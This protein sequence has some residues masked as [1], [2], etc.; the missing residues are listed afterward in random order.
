M[1]I[2]YDWRGMPI[3]FTQYP[4]PENT[5]VSG[6]TLYKMAMTYDGT[7]RRI[8]KTRWVKARGDAGWQ[9]RHVTH[10]TGIGTEVRE[11]FA[12]PAKETKVV[13]NMPQGLGRYGIEKA[14]HAAESGSA[15]TFEWFLKNHLGSTMLVYGTG[16]T[17]G[18][19]KAAY[20]YRSFGEQVTLTSPST[21]KVTENFTGK[22]RDDET[23]LVYFGARYL[24]PL[25]GMWISVVPARLFASPYLYAGN[26]MNPMNVIDPD[27][28]AA[29]VYKD[30]NEVNVYI[31]VIFSGEAATPENIAYIKKEVASFFTG[32]YGKY[33]VT[34]SIF[35]LPEGANGGDPSGINKVTLWNGP[36]PKSKCQRGSCAHIGREGTA[37]IDM[38]GK[39]RRYHV[40]H[41]FAHLLGLED[42][43]DYDTK[44]P[45]PTYENNLMGK[46]GQFDLKPEQ[47]EEMWVP[48]SRKGSE[49]N[50]VYGPEK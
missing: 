43:Y 16:G 1:K 49:G 18:G 21:G 36:A 25:L 4:S 9:R 19:L 42:K 20:D 22:E 37:N 8:S 45:Y 32:K 10:Y 47:I 17:S 33:D 5:G 29:T 38:T 6:D 15:Q 28:N 12:G 23:Q 24:D 30:G 13:V 3:E 46:A 34:V 48:N 7:G 11:N 39:L 41:E 2:L 31:P 26:G 40:L 27:G 14:D 50:N 44:K 35:E